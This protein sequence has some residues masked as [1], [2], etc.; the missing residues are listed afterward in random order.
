LDQLLKAY[1]QRMRT[2]KLKL[3]AAVGKSEWREV[4][5]VGEELDRMREEFVKEEGYRKYLLRKDIGNTF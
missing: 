1:H 2:L 3:E 5:E 4:I